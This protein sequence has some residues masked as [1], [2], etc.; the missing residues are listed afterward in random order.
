MAAKI[1]IVG[2]AWGTKEALFE[3]PFVG[4]SGREL[5]KM[6]GEAGLA[7]PPNVEYPSEIE[8]M[9]HWAR[10][11]A[12]Y[13][14]ELANVF[15]LRPED[16]KVDLCFAGV[17][18]GDTTLPPY[19]RGKYLRPELRPH[20]ER[21][22]GQIEAATPN[23]V[24]AFGNTACWA[25]LGETK[26]TALRGTIKRSPR[27]GVKVL[28]T[29][30]P[31][32]ILRQWNLR[33]IVVADLEKASREAQSSEIRRIERYLT[34]EPTIKEIEEWVERPAASYAVDIENNPC[35]ITMIGFARAADDAITIPF[36]DETRPGGSYWPTAA[37]EVRAWQLVAALLASPVP[38]IFQNGVYDLSHILRLGLRPV[39]CADDTML[40]HHALYP[41]MLKGLG[42]LGSIYSDEQ[43]WKTMRGKGNTLKR[44]E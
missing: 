43:A 30:H 28:P 20:V 18:E 33:L 13:G 36:Y 3:H 17:K 4:P 1:V 16:N 24:I 12:E 31:A 25:T 19:G 39:N 7:P 6:L 5:A 11:K 23:L 37:E 22:W 8:L 34:I 40:L 21:L 41:E 14:I 2:E 29:Y 32:A 9:A 44:D 15:N 10:L 35:C 38:K 42:F 27:L 26:I